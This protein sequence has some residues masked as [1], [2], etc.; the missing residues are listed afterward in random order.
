MKSKLSFKN[1]SEIE[2]NHLL[3]KAER[4]SD[5]LSD[6]SV[7]K[8]YNEYIGAMIDYYNLVFET[9]IESISLSVGVDPKSM[10]KS[11]EIDMNLLKAFKRLDYEKQWMLKNLFAKV[12]KT[13]ENLKK[14]FMKFTINKNKPLEPFKLFGKTIYD[15]KKKEYLTNQDTKEI[16]DGIVKFL[17]NYITSPKD[18]MVV[19]SMI[20]GKLIEKMKR[21][22]KTDK[23]IQKMSYEDIEKQN[24]KKFPNSAEEYYKTM[25]KQ[26][27]ITKKAMERAL[28]S[29]GRY[30][31]V[32]NSEIKNKIVNYTTKLISDGLGMKK[33][34]QQM[35]SEFYHKSKEHNSKGIEEWN[36]DIRRIILTETKDAME[37]GKLVEEKEYNDLVGKKTYMM[38]DGSVNPEEGMKEPCNVWLGK[39]GLVVEDPQSSDKTNDPKADFL[40]WPGKSNAGR[41]KSEWWMA[42]PVH[43]H[44]KHF[45][46]PLDPDKQRFDKE[47][48]KIVYRTK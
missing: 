34:N 6:F 37:S 25:S 24:G 28:T 36:R 27:R 48:R 22:G 40:I 29:A 46:S 14:H 21:E 8:F 39:I 7:Y 45:Y 18:E 13:F 12:A 26:E 30:L 10:K 35:I 44:C 23:Q 32:D 5:S 33:T 38:F 47:S 9:L 43:P 42:I 15:P 2:G 41:K 1:I 19:R 11:Y 16:S 31:S 3:L 4:E 20:F 17:G